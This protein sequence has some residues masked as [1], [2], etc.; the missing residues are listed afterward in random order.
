MVN[1]LLVRAG[2]IEKTPMF[3]WISKWFLVPF[4]CWKL[5]G[6]F[7][8]IS[9][10]SLWKLAHTPPGQSHNVLGGRLW[11]GLPM[12]CLHWASSN[13]SI[14]VQGF[15]L[16]ACPSPPPAAPL[17]QHLCSD[18]PQLPVG[19]C[20]SLLLG[21]ACLPLTYASKK[22][23]WFFSVFGFLLVWIK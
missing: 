14:A 12:T 1:Q 22:S 9:A 2:F 5:R 13:S 20:L 15:L 3:S 8:H 16:E 4:P 17:I 19:A 6:F 23:C 18:K 11:L 21:A 10:S 7:S